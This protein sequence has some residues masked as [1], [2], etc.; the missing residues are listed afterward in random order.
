M[1]FTLT[2][3]NYAG[4]VSSFIYLDLAEGNEV[5]QKG[6]AYLELEVPE[7]RS[8]PIL[9]QTSEPFGEYVA[10]PAAID[11]T[12]TTSYSE[13]QLILDKAMLYEL[14]NPNDFSFLWD[15]WKSVG[16]F[17]ELRMNPEFMRDVMSITKASAGAHLTSLFWAGD[18]AS[19]DPKKAITDGIIT[20]AAADA[21]TVK[22]TPAG[23]ITTANVIAIIQSVIDLIPDRH[24]NNPDFKIALSMKDF[25][26]LQRANN[27]LKEN[28]VGA[29]DSTISDMLETKKIMP[30]INF[31]AN[32]I[33]STLMGTTEL[34]NLVFGFWFDENR[35]FEDLRI[36]RLA[37]NSD[38]WFMRLNIKV[39]AQYRKSELVII[40]EP[41]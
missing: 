35:E 1:S 31:P 37:A 10:T 26:T 2:N 39:G 34:S 8:L 27:Q 22:A 23:N 15:K 11:Q 25:R 38:E 13:R 5:I 19:L 16:T 29:L 33:V 3:T 41:A 32:Y 18:K 36:D 14:F 40:Y 20:I 12:V 6:T 9:D 28:F 7:K 21:N 17:T 24:F 4:D 30:Y